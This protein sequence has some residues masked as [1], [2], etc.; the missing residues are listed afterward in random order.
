MFT[1]CRPHFI[2][3]KQYLQRYVSP[4]HQCSFVLLDALDSLAT[5]SNTSSC[6]PEGN[7]ID[8]LRQNL[9]ELTVNIRFVGLRADIVTI[10]MASQVCVWEVIS[11]VW[12]VL[13]MH[14][15]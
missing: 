5:I 2:A 10:L 1:E 3:L 11:I 8:A 6:I 12:Q 14:L 9:T 13:E 4:L 7:Q 15:R